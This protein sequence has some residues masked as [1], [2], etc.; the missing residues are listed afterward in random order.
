ELP[1]YKMPEWGSVFRNVFDRGRIFVTE[2]GKII[3]AISVILW[4]LASFPK[5]EMP[6]SGTQA[7]SVSQAAT[8]TAQTEPSFNPN[9]KPESYQLKHSYA[10]QFGQFIEPVVEPLGFD[11]KIGI[12]LLTSFA[13]REVM[14][15]TLNTI[16]SVQG[17]D[18]ENTATLQEKLK[19]EIDPE[20]GKPVFTT[21]TA[22]SLM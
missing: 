3:M 4:F 20:T 21:L 1:S 7:G 13:A 22:V 16:Y 6:Q 12:G 9:V 14:V 2:A 11:W 10:G 15:G 17:G 5:A 18:E 19:S 8:V